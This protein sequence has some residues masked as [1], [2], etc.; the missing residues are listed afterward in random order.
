MFA[1]VG[2]DKE[3]TGDVN[4]DGTVYLTDMHYTEAVTKNHVSYIPVIEYG[5]FI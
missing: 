3:F 4:D 2:D 5:G 1:H